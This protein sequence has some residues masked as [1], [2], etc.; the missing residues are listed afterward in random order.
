MTDYIPESV[1]DIFPKSKTDDQI[2]REAL[3]LVA[4]DG[5]VRMRFIIPVAEVMFTP[6][7]ARVLA[8]GL[9]AMAHQLDPNGG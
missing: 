2:L 7:E 6:N 8:R 1:R 3:A 9:I 4:G 5:Q